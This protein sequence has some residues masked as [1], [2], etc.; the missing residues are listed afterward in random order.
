MIFQELHHEVEIS[1]LP[2][3]L[4]ESFHIDLTGAVYGD[5]LKIEELEEFKNDAYEFLDQQDTVLYSITES[6]VHLEQDPDLETVAAD[7][8][9]QVGEE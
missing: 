8:I 5:S 3:D 2:K 4:I 7:E 1:V 6:Y 9:P